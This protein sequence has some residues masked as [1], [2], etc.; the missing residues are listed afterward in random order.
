MFFLIKKINKKNKFFVYR[1]TDIIVLHFWWHL[2]WGFKARMDSLACVIHHLCAT[3]S[4]DSPLVQHLMA[5]SIAAEQ[6]HQRLIRNNHRSFSWLT[7]IELI[8]THNLPLKLFLFQLFILTFNLLFLVHVIV[9]PRLLWEKYL[10]R[11][12]SSISLGYLCK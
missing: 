2:S 4:S 3:N 11:L 9:F 8:V 12:L 1:A 7:I 10:M 5:A 6:F